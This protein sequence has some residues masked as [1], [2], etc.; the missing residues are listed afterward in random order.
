MLKCPL[1]TTIHDVVFNKGPPPTVYGRKMRYIAGNRKTGP[2]T[3]LI[4]RSPIA[5]RSRR[6]GFYLPRAGGT[7]EDSPFRSGDPAARGKDIE[8]VGHGA[9]GFKNRS[10]PSA[11]R[12]AA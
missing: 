3:Y 11:L 12:W 9:I 7:C 10:G 8:G 5:K 4:N 2:V 6:V 1:V